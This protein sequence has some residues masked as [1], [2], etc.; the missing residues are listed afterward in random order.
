MVPGKYKLIL[1]G[2]PNVGKTSLIRRWTQDVF[3][4]EKDTS[5]DIQTKEVPVGNESVQLVLTDTAGQERFRYDSSLHALESFT[6][7]FLFFFLL[8]LSFLLS[9]LSFPSPDI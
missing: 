9:S 7:H 4:E 1:L 5:I 3:N 8:S 6:L 2:S